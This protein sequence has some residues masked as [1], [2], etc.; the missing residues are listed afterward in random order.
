VSEI[1]DVFYAYAHM[2]D[3]FTVG[4]KE[5]SMGMDDHYWIVFALAVILML[6]IEHINSKRNLIEWTE[7]QRAI[8]RW[9]IYFAI[10]FV[11]FL[12][13]AFGV[14]NFIYVQF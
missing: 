14:D 7:Q 5:L 4:I 10:V 12:Y 6:L 1:S 8:I 3:G 2:F 11:I 9:P 13:G